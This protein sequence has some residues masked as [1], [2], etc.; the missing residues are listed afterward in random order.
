MNEIIGGSFTSRINMNLRENKHWSYG[1]RSLLISTKGQ[2]LFITY[3]P[4][5]T[6][7]TVESIAEIKR[8]LVEY[9]SEKPATN[10]ELSKVK[11]NNTFSL[12]GRWETANAVLRDIEDIVTYDLPDNYWDTYAGNVRSLSL[13]QIAESAN[14]VI[15]P[16]NLVWVVVGDREKIEPRINELELDEIIHL[17]VDGNYL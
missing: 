12:P 9:L 1:A 17:D 10:E 7:K 11:D 4:V 15:K 13:D 14:N 6:D 2:R 3:A 5:Q 8:E 16:H